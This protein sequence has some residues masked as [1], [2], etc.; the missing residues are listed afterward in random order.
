[1]PSLRDIKAPNRPIT[2]DFSGTPVHVTYDPNAITPR[3]QE[4]MALA[5]SNGENTVKEYLT[6]LTKW[7]VSWDL[8]EDDDVT[9]LALTVDVLKD[10]PDSVL[11]AI[12]KALLDDMRPNPTNS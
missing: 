4:E 1:M 3:L 11:S 12:S 2:I 6:I 7:I 5:A 10:I 9:P 8:T